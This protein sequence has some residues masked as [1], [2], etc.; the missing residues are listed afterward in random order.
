M[1]TLNLS[2]LSREHIILLNKISVSII[3]DYNALIEY[4]FSATDKSVDWLV[5]STLSRN[6]YMNPLF[7][8]LCYLQ[9]I[10][11][12]IKND[13]EIK[14]IVVPNK[15]LKEVLS[16]SFKRKNIAIEIAV[17][18]DNLS[19]KE[20]IKRRRVRPLFDLYLNAHRLFVMWLLGRKK[21][22]DAAPRDRAI[23]LIDTFFLPSMFKNNKFNDRYYP[24][25]LEHLSKDEKRDIFFTP[26]ILIRNYRDLKKALESAENAEEQFFLRIDYL[27]AVDY[28]FALTS[29]IRIKKIKF[30]NFNIFGYN[31]GPLLKNHF[32]K[33]VLN[34]SSLAGLL[35]Y[36]FFK[37]LRESGVKLHKVIDW[38][39]NQIIDRGFNK[40]VN[41][42]YPKVLRTGYQG[43]II[44]SDF[45]FYIHP[46]K[47][48]VDSGIVPDEI[49]VVGRELVQDGKEYCKDLNVSAAPAFRFNGVWQEHAVNARDENNIILVALPISFK[50]SEEI[51]QLIIDMLRIEKS[52][53]LIFHIKPHPALNI[54]GLKRKFGGEWREEFSTVDGDF[55]ERVKESF[56]MLGNTSSTCVETL[57]MGI[58]VIIIGSQSGLTQNPIPT[59]ISNDLW[60]LCYTPYELRDAIDYFVDHK[61]G[62]KASFTDN[63]KRIREQCFEPVTREGVR[64]FLGIK[65]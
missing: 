7:I 60:R 40:G 62:M 23:I 59:T 17:I 54:D 20:I 48:E 56:L 51:I 65:E 41:D 43:Y 47:W 29:P 3:G 18:N 11:V 38:N 5:S 53:D 61:Q 45:N 30:N 58:S 14:K 64:E 27:K 25:L 52:D 6:T 35:N 16:K 32:C 55:T 10:K 39:E 1:K 24:G 34:P 36:R 19:F 50:E 31:I 46:T 4:I 15:E 9:F 13:K 44:S 33:N 57:A 22:K 42:Y 37:R 63:A 26:E 12:V 49:G 28:L 21:R 2:N 8:N